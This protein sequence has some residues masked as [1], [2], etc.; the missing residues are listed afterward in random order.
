MHSKEVTLFHP[1]SPMLEKEGMV[2]PLAPLTLGAILEERGHKVKVIDA[3]S[4]KISTGEL[5][6]CDFLMF[7]SVT[8]VITGR[9]F[10]TTG[11]NEDVNLIYQG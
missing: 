8:T 1:P 6:D 5:I 10:S 2:P 11:Q 9:C 7:T 3:R 4:G